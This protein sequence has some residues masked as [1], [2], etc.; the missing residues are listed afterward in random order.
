[1]STLDEIE[2][3]IQKLAPGDLAAFRTW[4]AEFDATAWDRDLERDVED[5]RLDE[6]A[7]E[8]LGELA[9]GRCTDL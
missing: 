4:Y 3:A 2:K 5:G 1:M 9:N 6:L 8:A 7:Q